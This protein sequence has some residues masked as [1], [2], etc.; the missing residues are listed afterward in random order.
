MFDIPTVIE[1]I[2]HARIEV[3]EYLSV[4]DLIK[5]KVSVSNGVNVLLQGLSTEAIRVLRVIQESPVAEKIELVVGE[6][7]G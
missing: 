3:F 1:L 5:S 7:D 4:K 2:A 6:P